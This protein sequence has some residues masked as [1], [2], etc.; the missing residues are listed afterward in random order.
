MRRIFAKLRCHSCPGS[1]PPVGP[2]PLCFS[3][4]HRTRLTS[5]PEL[6]SCCLRFLTTRPSPGLTC[7]PPRRRGNES[8]LLAH[9]FP[10]KEQNHRALH[11]PGPWS[12]LRGISPCS[13]GNRR[14]HCPESL[15]PS[16]GLCL[17]QECP[18]LASR[19]HPPSPVQ[20]V[21]S[22][23]SAPRT[24]SMRCLSRLLATPGFSRS[25]QDYKTLF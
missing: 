9:S 5:S 17:G 12:P 24:L 25:L 18:P 6:P 2:H 22:P 8:P 13:P 14:P 10:E 20:I 1:D 15:L 7:V 4:R 3:S 11:N 16:P 21:C 19:K 23:S